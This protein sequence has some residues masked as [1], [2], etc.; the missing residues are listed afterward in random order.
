MLTPPSL[1][2]AG[3]LPCVDGP[4]VHPSSGPFGPSVP[5]PI[6]NIG[7][8]HVGVQVSVGDSASILLERYPEVE[9]LEH[10]F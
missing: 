3:H 1:L 8:V 5:W 9:L 7:P 10:T 6:K 4:C 2:E